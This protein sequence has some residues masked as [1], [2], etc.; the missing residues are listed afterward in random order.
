MDLNRDNNNSSDGFSKKS[1]PEID[2]QDEKKIDFKIDPNI[3]PI[4]TPKSRQKTSLRQRYEAEAEV[5]AKKIGD[6]ESVRKELGLSQ[7]KMCE[8]LLVD[9]SAWTRWQKNPKKVPPH[10]FRSLQWY[11]ALIE[12]QPEWHPQ[13]SFSGAAKVLNDKQ[14]F[15]LSQK[16][17]KEWQAEGLLSRSWNALEEHK[18]E[19]NR[20]RFEMEQ[21]IERKEQLTATWKLLLLLN[22]AIL[23][24]IVILMF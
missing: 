6:L 1:S 8:L 24:G 5:I 4:L 7:R 23:V 16:M 17:K 22:T 21:K 19:W 3:P 14:L 2:L 10:I 12:K 11:M 15:E 20:Q 18:D 9:P 13:N